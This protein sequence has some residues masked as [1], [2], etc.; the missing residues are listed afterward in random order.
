MKEKV[1]IGI[2]SRPIYSK[3]NRNML[4]V[5]E[6]Y[7]R[8][9]IKADGIPLII[10]P[11]QDI[12][13]ENENINI[14]LNEVEVSNLREVLKLCNGIIM[15]GGDSAFC[16][17]YEILKYAIQNKIPILGICLGMQVMCTL[18]GKSL[19]LVNNHDN[20]YH[21]VRIVENT[22]LYKIFKQKKNCVNSRHKEQ[23]VNSGKYMISAIS[24]DGV[25]EAVEYKTDIFNI[26]VQWHP[27]DLKEEN[28]LFE[29][30]VKCAKRNMTSFR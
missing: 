1:I 14:K 28:I 22:K 10:S 27:E 24:D 29:E 18:E 5:Y 2:V 3:S 25:I 13:Y 19:I 12:S 15:P 20:T 8:A 7:I 16:Y 30:L 11:Q 4:G 9:V 26:G 17:D 21:N 23:V 6:T